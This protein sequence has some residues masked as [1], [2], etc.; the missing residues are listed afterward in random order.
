MSS[1]IP[2]LMFSQTLVAFIYAMNLFKAVRFDIAGR[3]ETGP[4]L[5]AN[6]WSPSFGNGTTSDIFQE[7]GNVED[8]K[9]WFTMSVSA[10]KIHV[11]PSLLTEIGTLS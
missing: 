4:L 7:A 8:N 1:F 2:T 5:F 10:G 11:K 6:S 3:K 9:E